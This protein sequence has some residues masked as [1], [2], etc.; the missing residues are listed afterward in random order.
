MK[1]MSVSECTYTVQQS[2]SN[3]S[4]TLSSGL[5][6]WGLITL[7]L[8][9]ARAYAFNYPVTTDLDYYGV[10]GAGMVTTTVQK[11]AMPNQLDGTWVPAGYIMQPAQWLGNNPSVIYAAAP[12][13][14]CTWFCIR[15]SG[16][17]LKDFTER[18]TYVKWTSDLTVNP[19][20]GPVC[21]GV[22]IRAD[23]G[24]GVVTTLFYRPPTYQ[25]SCV[26]PR[27]SC[28][29]NTASA[30]LDHGSLT[31]A[32]AN[33]HQATTSLQ[34]ECTGSTNLRFLLKNGY[35][36]QRISLSN[37]GKSKISVGGR[38]MGKWINTPSGKSTHT[39]SDTLEIGSDVT[40]GP[41]SGNAILQ[42]SVE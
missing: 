32:N 10:P 11:R 8:S 42:I 38:D 37:G 9:C 2:K 7:L 13:N 6:F 23:S 3:R 27:N 12:V 26:Y 33:N 21:S 35:D 19:A 30:T 15:S 18:W 34:V 29:F 25:G 14:N 20:M 4:F 40:P 5:F 36:S 24:T 16:E 41:F 22:I 28:S 31:E 1:L 39:L 17:Y